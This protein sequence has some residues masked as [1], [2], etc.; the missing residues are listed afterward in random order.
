MWKIVPII[1]GT[2]YGSIPGQ[3]TTPR[4]IIIYYPDAFSHRYYVGVQGGT[5]RECLN[6]Y[7]ANKEHSLRVHQNLDTYKRTQELLNFPIIKSFL[8]ENHV[9]LQ[10]FLGF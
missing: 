7:Q 8:L 3:P 2:Y 5:R 6:Y 9:I 4:N 10:S 1:R